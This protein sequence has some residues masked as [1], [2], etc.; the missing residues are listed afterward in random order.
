MNYEWEIFREGLTKH[1]RVREISYGNIEVTYGHHL[2]DDEGN[3]VIENKIQ[4][5]YTPRE[6]VDFFGPIVNTLKK[7]IDNGI[8]N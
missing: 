3:T 2:V 1:L 7:D 8:G 6:F 4:T 5:F